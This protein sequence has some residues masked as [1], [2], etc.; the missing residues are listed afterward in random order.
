VPLSRFSLAARAGIR[1]ISVALL[2]RTRALP[3]ILRRLDGSGPVDA[4]PDPLKIDEAARVVARVARLRVFDLPFFPRLCLRRSLTLFSLLAQ[5]GH[6]PEIHF[7]VRSDR[8]VLD[9]HSWITID[10]AALGENA[11]QAPIR[12]VYSYSSINRSEIGPEPSA[13]PASASC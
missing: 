2:V 12:I 9:G 5:K 7:G 13:R 4:A 6:A 10:G 1:L 8:G 3:D 11:P